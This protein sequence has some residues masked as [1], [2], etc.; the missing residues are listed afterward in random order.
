MN[1]KRWWC[2]DCHTEVELDKHGR[3]G[4]CESE[5]VDPVGHRDG[6]TRQSSLTDLDVTTFPLYT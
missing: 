2:M 5:A 6:S 1:A 4:S 3:C